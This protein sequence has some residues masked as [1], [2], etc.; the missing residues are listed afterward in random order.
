MLGLLVGGAWVVFM[1]RADLQVL[2]VR[3]GSIEKAIHAAEDK[4]SRLTDVTVTL[5]R[6][7]ERMNSLERRMEDLSHRTSIVTIPAPM[8]VIAK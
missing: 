3:V 7:D 4:I 2:G 1:Q 8:P 6:Q 5:A